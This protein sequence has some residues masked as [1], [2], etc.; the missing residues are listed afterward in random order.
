MT[1]RGHTHKIRRASLNSDFYDAVIFG[2]G[3]ILHTVEV[4]HYVGDDGASESWRKS[5]RGYEK[6]LS[7]ARSV[8]DGKVKN[9]VEASGSRY[10]DPVPR[11]KLWSGFSETIYKR[12]PRV[13]D[14]GII[15]HFVG[16]GWVDEGEADE[17]HR[18]LYP[19]VV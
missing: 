7:Y 1:M 18:L 9:P 11:A 8:C 17:A 4:T 13:I 14:H 19:E 3:G 6:A 12:Y 10:P 2:S 5:F 16:F 15:K